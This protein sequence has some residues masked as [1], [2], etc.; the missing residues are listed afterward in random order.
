M[1]PAVAQSWGEVRPLEK[2]PTA[3]L[4][5]PFDAAE[6]MPQWVLEMNEI[7]MKRG[8]LIRAL[9]PEGVPRLWCPLLAH[10]KDDGSLD[11]DRMVAH[12]DF[13]SAFIKVS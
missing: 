4:S 5:L 7:E 11:M 13:V 6:G 3:A 2:R 10:Y 12:F 8:E 9:V 1:A